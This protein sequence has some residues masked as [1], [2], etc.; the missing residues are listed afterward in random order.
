M[1]LASIFSGPGKI[2]IFGLGGVALFGGVMMFIQK[3]MGK[4]SEKREIAHNAVQEKIQQDI[5]KVTKEQEVIQK[6]LVQAEEASVESKEKIKKIAR[7]AAVEMNKVLKEDSI[8]K[9]DDQIDSDW[10]SL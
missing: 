1:D 2:A 9:I 8:A 6:Q 10:E 3:F 4:R 7:K 5:K